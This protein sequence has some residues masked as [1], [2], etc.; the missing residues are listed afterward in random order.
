MVHSSRVLVV[1]VTSGLILVKSGNR[2]SSIPH[3]PQ[4]LLAPLPAGRGLGY[5]IA[6]AV[7]P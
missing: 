7:S 5:P 6:I 1:K 4:L 3:R 2:L